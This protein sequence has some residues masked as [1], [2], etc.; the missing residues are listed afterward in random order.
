MTGNG[1]WFSQ[2]IDGK[3]SNK[4]VLGDNSTQTIQGYGNIP[5]KLK[6]GEIGTLK[7]YCGFLIWQEIC[8]LWAA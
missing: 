7:M 2:Y 6:N 8:F 1:D 4:V 3:G 5:I